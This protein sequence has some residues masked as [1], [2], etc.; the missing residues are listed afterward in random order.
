M[1]ET[2]RK[3]RCPY[4][5]SGSQFKPMKVLDNDRQMCEGCGHIVY[6]R[7]DAFLCLCQ[8]CITAR[9]SPARKL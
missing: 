8:R 4:C 1:R 2:N 7:D 5:V 9:F 3:S 6:P